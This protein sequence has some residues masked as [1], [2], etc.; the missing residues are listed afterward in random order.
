MASKMIDEHG[1]FKNQLGVFHI[2]P[3]DPEIVHK[4]RLVICG[5]A[6]DASDADLIMDIMG[7]K[8]EHGPAA[9]ERGY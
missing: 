9:V 7:L 3:L 4:A 1:Q 5:A 8:E 6:K 2:P